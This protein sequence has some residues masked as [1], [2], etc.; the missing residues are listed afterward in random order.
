R[1]GVARREAPAVDDEP[2][3]RRLLAGALDADAA[4]REPLDQ[5]GERGARIEMRLLREEERIGGAP[6]QVGLQHGERLRIEATMARGAAREALELAA[7]AR[8]REHQR[9]L[10][11]HDARV[12]LPPAG[13]LPA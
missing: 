9:A 8:E 10:R 1:Q 5:R 11:T 7:V 4:P 13:R 3:A 6:G 12:P 2:V